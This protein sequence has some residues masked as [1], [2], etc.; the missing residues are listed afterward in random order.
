[1]KRA[2]PLKAAPTIPPAGQRPRRRATNVT[3]DEA[4][5]DE[6]R[7]LGLNLSQ[8]FEAHLVAVLQQHRVAAWQKENAEAFDAYNAFVARAGIWNED[9]REW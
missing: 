6:A 2:Q 9:D 5:V 1:M 7:A 8:V 4:L 3:L